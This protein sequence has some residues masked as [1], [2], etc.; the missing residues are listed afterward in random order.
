MTRKTYQIQGTS[1][2][3]YL[4]AGRDTALI[5]IREVGEEKR[6]NVGDVIMYERN[7][8][9]ILHRIVGIKEDDRNKNTVIY[10]VRGD[11]CYNDEFIAPDI[12]T[13]VAI[14][15]TRK[16][17]TIEVTSRKYQKY[18]NRILKKGIKPNRKRIIF[19]NGIRRIINFI[20]QDSLYIH[21]RGQYLYN[22]GSSKEIIKQL[23][24]SHQNNIKPYLKVIENGII[25]PR[26]RFVENGRIVDKGG[27]L[28]QNG[29]F[30]EE[31]IEYDF[32]GKYGF[33]L[34]NVQTIEEPVIYLGRSFPHFGVAFIDLLRR[35]YFK[36]SEEGKNMKMC[37]CGVYCE[38]GTFGKHDKKS[39]DL[40]NAIGIYKDELIDV[41][42]PT[43]F[44]QIYIPEPGFEYEKWYKNEFYIPY[45]ILFDKAEPREYK[46]VYLS[47][48]RM[49]QKKDAGEKIIQKFFSMNGYEVFYPDEISIEEQVEYLK[50]ADCIA[51]IEGTISHNILF[52]TP[53][54]K[55]IIIRRD[56]RIE[57]RH[58]LLNE[59]MNSV[60]T[61]IDCYFNILPGFPRHYDIGPFCML[62]NKNIR[63]FAKDNNYKIPRGWVISNVKTF[64]KYCSLCINQKKSEKKNK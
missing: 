12:I 17:R 58:F 22:T 61:Y 51:S 39:W 21:D 63:K 60:P 4:K 1:M 41:R 36:Y 14:E 31:S 43:R 19:Q 9:Y 45:K 8:R 34:L 26:K 28:D 62:F 5:E 53:G 37:C 7:E 56:T 47:R 64:L 50:G 33:D 29:N 24:E 16:G 2:L 23:S 59:L 35:A 20:L 10:V 46:K 30:V 38:P 15:F 42:V 11:N 6:F 18:A 40:L 27:V 48:G 3:P 44:T 25:L 49:P 52:C 57:P 54:T 55:Q 32:G 13:G